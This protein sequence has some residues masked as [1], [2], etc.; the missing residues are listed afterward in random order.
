MPKILNS[1]II[2]SILQYLSCH[3]S[4]IRIPARK[5]E[6]LKKNH[7]YPHYIFFSYPVFFFLFLA[8]VLINT[9]V[10]NM[11]LKVKKK[12]YNILLTMYGIVLLYS[13]CIVGRYMILDIHIHTYIYTYIYTYIHTYTPA[14]LYICQLVNFWK[15]SH[16]SVN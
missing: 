15:E 5:C 1:L 16:H 13:K 8:R 12:V 2:L 9:I 10:N 4:L 6:K 11:A 7:S 3:L 14:I